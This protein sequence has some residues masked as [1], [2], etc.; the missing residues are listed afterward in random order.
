MGSTN[1]LS[2]TVEG[3]GGGSSKAG[4]KHSPMNR[5]VK[6]KEKE[7]YSKSHQTAASVSKQIQECGEPAISLHSYTVPPFQWSTR[8]LP[9]M[10]DPGSIRGGYLCKTGIIL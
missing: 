9:I 7:S 4:T 10:R 5:E 6:S 3:G 1:P 8:L 2:I